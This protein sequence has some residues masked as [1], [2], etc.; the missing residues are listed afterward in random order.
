V[1]DEE[2]EQVSV[3]VLKSSIKKLAKGAEK[4]NI[5]HVATYYARILDKYAKYFEAKEDSLIVEIELLRDMF[6]DP[7]R[8][9]ENAKKHAERKFSVWEI[10]DEVVSLKNFERRLQEW[11]MIADMKMKKITDNKSI[12]FTL[13]HGVNKQWSKF[14]CLMNIFILEEMGENVKDHTIKNLSWSITVTI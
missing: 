4:R 6:G 7:K 9:E 13:L 1:V 8:V 12:T 3:R 14:Q 11:C 10:S 5:P 2:R